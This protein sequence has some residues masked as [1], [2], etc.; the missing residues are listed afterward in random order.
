MRPYSMMGSLALL[1]AT[2]CLQ[3]C[4]VVA[5][6][7]IAGAAAGAASASRASAD[8]PYTSLTYA[9]TVVGNAGYV[10]TKILFAGAGAA[11]SGLM[12]IVTVGDTERS[13]ELWTT[14]VEGTYVLTP[15][16]IAGRAPVHFVAPLGEGSERTAPVARTSANPPGSHAVL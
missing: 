9:G 12:Y 2:A 7:A 3:G 4:G 5:A 6:G 16:M 10:P 11:A 1:L 13:N 15:E 14:T 8:H